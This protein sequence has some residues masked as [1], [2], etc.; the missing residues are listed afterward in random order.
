MLSLVEVS[1]G[2]D[3]LRALFG[4]SLEVAAGE[5]VGVIGPNGA[6]KTTLMRVISGLVGAF[7]G[8]IT[9]DGRSIVG[10][11]A[12]RIVEQNVQQVLEVVDRAYLLEVG[13]IRLSGSSTELKNNEFIRKAYMGL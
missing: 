6:G 13:S 11:P 4:V 1:A 2:Y 9:L 3:S 10:A 8:A 12:H 5:T 7:A